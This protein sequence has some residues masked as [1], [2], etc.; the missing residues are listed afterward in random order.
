MAITVSFYNNKSD[1]R[2]LTKNLNLLVE[3]VQ[4]SVYLPCD[5]LNPILILDKDTIPNVLSLCNYCVIP[6]FSRK[7]FIESIQGAAGNKIQVNC[8]V[9]VLGTYDEE[10][11]YCPLIAARSSNQPNYY[12]DDEM[13]IFDSRVINQYINIGTDIGAPSDIILITV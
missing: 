1:N 5:R 9:D 6:E 4:C 2:Y 11:R 8:H 3:N 13:R 7:Y 12:L 10:I